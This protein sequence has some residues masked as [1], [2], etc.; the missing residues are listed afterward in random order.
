MIYFPINSLPP[1]GVGR[2]GGMAAVD[3]SLIDV[4]D[5][6]FFKT[7]CFWKYY[8]PRRFGLTVSVE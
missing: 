8:F 5:N 6:C 7:I 2:V 3:Q 4:K 1:H